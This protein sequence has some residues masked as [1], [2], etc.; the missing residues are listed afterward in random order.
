MRWLDRAILLALVIAIGWLAASGRPGTAQSYHS[1]TAH[2]VR[3]IVNSAIRDA[4]LA[5]R[6][7]VQNV[8]RAALN[9]CRLTGQRLE[10]DSE[11]D[12]TEWVANL[13]C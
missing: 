12:K 11:E 5:S 4:G 2:D 13:Q 9:R 6:Q 3:V 1:L 10:P 7:D 8:V